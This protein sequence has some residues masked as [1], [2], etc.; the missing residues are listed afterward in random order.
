MGVCVAII[1]ESTS[2][3]IQIFKLIFFGNHVKGCNSFHKI[4][5][6]KWLDY[7]P[8]FVL[9]VN[10]INTGGQQGLNVC[11]RARHLPVSD[12]KSWISILN[13]ILHLKEMAWGFYFESKNIGSEVCGLKKQI[14]KFPKSNNKFPVQDLRKKN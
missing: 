12:S 10:V 4:H 14:L 2:R 11:W 9:K 1:F 6:S 3:K 8:F 13:L 7:I 5:L